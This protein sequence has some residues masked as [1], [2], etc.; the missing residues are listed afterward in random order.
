MKICPKLDCYYICS[1]LNLGQIE[2]KE[3]L[4]KAIE[5]LKQNEVEGIINSGKLDM[6][7][8]AFFVLVKDTLHVI[9]EEDIAKVISLV[10]E[11]VNIYN[12][13][14]LVESQWR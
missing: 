6:L 2:N 10:K 3:E 1:K 13:M 11:H 4:W 7:F 8:R 9:T 5:Q 14:K 12:N